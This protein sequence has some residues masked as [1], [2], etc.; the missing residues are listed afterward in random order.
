MKH[1]HL[2]LTTALAA[3]ICFLPLH[4]TA[5]SPKPAP[6]AMRHAA[7]I[8]MS[9]D[10]F[11]RVAPRVHRSAVSLEHEFE[12]ERRGNEKLTRRQFLIASVLSHNLGGDHP[13]VTTNAILKDLRMGR[14]FRR[15]LE[16]RGLSS[17]QALDAVRQAEREVG[18]S[19]PRPRQPSGGMKT[20]APGAKKDTT[21][22]RGG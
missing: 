2:A 7:A 19:A 10:A 9:D 5:Q 3:S 22:V 12:R 4:L 21:K 11:A 8:H 20:D 17:S 15:A 1:Q 14:T 6:P 18:Q 13:D 16:G